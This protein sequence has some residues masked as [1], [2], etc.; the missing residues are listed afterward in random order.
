MS[1]ALLVLAV[2]A[3][4]SLVLAQAPSAAAPDANVGAVE[5]P[6][7]SP[8]TAA[9]PL[10]SAGTG[11]VKEGENAGTQAVPEL[12]NLGAAAG[13]AAGTAAA[14]PSLQGDTTWGGRPAFPQVLLPAFV[15]TPSGLVV[16][17]I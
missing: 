13:G 9:S 12:S 5:T 14:L 7:V 10:A 2:P 17:P 3:A 16:C 11:D 6:G 4:N 1:F 15:A 8:P